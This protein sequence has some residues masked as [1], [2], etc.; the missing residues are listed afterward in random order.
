MVQSVILSKRKTGE[1]GGGQGLPP[2]P[3]LPSFVQSAVWALRPLPFMDRCQRRFGE[4]FTLRVRAG[5][6]WVFVTNPEHIKQ[7]FTTPPDLV[8]AAAGEANPL[9]GPLLGAGSVMLQD[10]PNHMSDRRRL[11]PSFHGDLMSYYGKMMETVAREQ[12]AIWPLGEPFA[13]WPRMQAVSLEVVMRTVFGDAGGPRL[14]LLRERL[15][16]LTSWMNNPRR[17]ALVAAGRADVIAAS[18]GF[19]AAMRPVEQLVLEEVHERRARGEQSGEGILASLERGHAESGAVM[20]DDK[21]RDELVTMLSDGPTATSL[22]WVFEKLLAHPEKLRRLREEVD[23]GTGEEYLDAVVKETLRLCPTV[24]V[25]MRNLVEPMQIDGWTVP[26]GTIVAPCVY[27]THLREDLYPEPHEFRPER[28]LDGRAGTYN[29][30]PFGGGARRCVA[31]SFAPLEMRRVINTVLE[32][33]ELRSAEM[34]DVGAMRSS[35]SFAP[36]S[37]ALV[38]ATRR[39]SRIP[40]VSIA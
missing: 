14:E 30:I 28:F 13:L 6:P 18:R 20:P 23:A 24:P 4:T 38:I 26:A 22:A 16:E 29:W 15:V 25:V 19:K 3:R 27:L 7:V 31:A 10:E 9:L 39:P 2:G 12:I 35:V 21:L 40:E 37:G 17:L 1:P 11:L 8:R 32:E 33:V 5:R 36:Q 34:G